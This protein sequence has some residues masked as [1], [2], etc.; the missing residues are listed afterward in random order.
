MDGGEQMELADRRNPEVPNCL[1]DQSEM[2]PEGWNMVDQLSVW[3]CSLCLFYTKERVPP[4]M[5]EKWGKV[6]VRV[7]REVL[8]ATSSLA[9]CRALKMFLQLPQAFLR[10]VKRRGQHAWSQLPG[11]IGEESSEA[12]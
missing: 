9:L 8:R 4:E 1:T 6:V 2:D 7:L 11:V 5:K 10:Q 12:L 3:D